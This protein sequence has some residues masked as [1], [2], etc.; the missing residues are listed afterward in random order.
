MKVKENDEVLPISPFSKF[1]EYT[2]FGR[3]CKIEKYDDIKFLYIFMICRK[4]EKTF[5]ANL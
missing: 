5:T 1:K 4:K 2:V 3:T